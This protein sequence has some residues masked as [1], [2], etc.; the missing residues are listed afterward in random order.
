MINDKLLYWYSSISHACCC[1]DQHVFVA[2]QLNSFSTSRDSVY[3]GLWLSLFLFAVSPVWGSGS[4]SKTQ[5]NAKSCAS[6]S[7]C[8]V[9]QCG[10]S[11]ESLSRRNKL[12]IEECDRRSSVVRCTADSLTPK[13]VPICADGVCS[14]KYEEGAAKLMRQNDGEVRT[15]ADGSLEAWD[16]R[17][18]EWVNLEQ[19]W[20]RYAARR[21]G[22]TWGRR[23][24][25][26][27]YQEVDELDTMI[28]EL[29]SGPC[30][31]EFFHTRWRR[32]NDV[33]RWDATF[34]EYGGCPYV[35]D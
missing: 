32:A 18:E 4:M 19:F 8:V 16:A 12:A 5:T 7:D 25:Y 20:D 28:I 33:R 1:S 14:K 15:N 35:F 27:R 11:W 30:L 17:E 3:N 31:M 13:P 26:P 2:S 34:N 24:D 9:V 10:C 22:L 6:T 29:E 23:F 21:G